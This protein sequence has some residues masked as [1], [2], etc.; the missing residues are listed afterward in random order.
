MKTDG[1]AAL[2]FSPDGKRLASSTG[3]AVKIWDIKT[4]SECLTN[5]ERLPARPTYSSGSVLSYGRSIGTR[6]TISRQ[7]P[8]EF[9]PRT[10]ETV[11]AARGEG[12][13]RQ[14]EGP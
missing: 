13:L 8:F 4:G 12:L 10:A 5:C 11:D 3:G 7:T 2:A 14:D 9:F 1:V 6:R